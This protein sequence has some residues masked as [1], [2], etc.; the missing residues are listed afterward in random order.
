MVR[1]PNR[2]QPRELWHKGHI[3]RDSTYSLKVHESPF[4]EH[5]TAGLG[6]EAAVTLVVMLIVAYFL[7][8]L[9]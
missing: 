5:A 2:G 4:E 7:V 8:K 6:R 3:L 1:Q 9:K